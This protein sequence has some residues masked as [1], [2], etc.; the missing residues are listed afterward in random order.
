MILKAENLWCVHNNRLIFN[1]IGF[2]VAPNKCLCIQGPNGSGKSS[3]LQMLA[4]FIRPYMGK[5]IWNDGINMRIVIQPDG[6]TSDLTV[7]E[8]EEYWQE[9][10]GEASAYIFSLQ[11]QTSCLVSTL[12]RGE[13]QKLALNK[14]HHG[15][16]KLW[17]LDEPFT[18]LDEHAC[19]AL[20]VAMH[21]QLERGG[22]IIFT[23]HKPLKLPFKVDHILKLE[24]PY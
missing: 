3:L 17:I 19:K 13:R 12:S 4:G 22:S 7:Q 24:S 10:F 11:H 20:G 18:A 2:T 9:L 16:S 23:S 1:N 8:T 15:H 21:H 14:L 5:V 6:L